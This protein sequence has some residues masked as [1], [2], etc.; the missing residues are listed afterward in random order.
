MNANI[1]TQSS[2]FTV[3]ALTSTVKALPKMLF[4]DIR[5]GEHFLRTNKNG[6]G[7]V[8]LKTGKRTAMLLLDANGRGDKV[9]KFKSDAKV[10]PLNATVDLSIASLTEAG[11]IESDR[12]AANVSH[13]AALRTPREVKPLRR[14]L[15][16]IAAGMTF[17]TATAAPTQ[18]AYGA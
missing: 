4:G 7:K 15:E 9:M 18:N 11:K 2:N 16:N 1:Y 3:P 12:R 10:I 14:V 5:I 8:F 6:D 17:P 13:V